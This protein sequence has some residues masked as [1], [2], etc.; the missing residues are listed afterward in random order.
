MNNNELDSRT[1]PF[2]EGRDDMI[3]ERLVIYLVNNNQ[4]MRKHEAKIQKRP[5]PRKKKPKPGDKTRPI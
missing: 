2:K 3:V 5:Q 4:G 1:N